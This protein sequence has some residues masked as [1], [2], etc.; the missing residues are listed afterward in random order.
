MPRT[1]S[2]PKKKSKS[3]SRRPLTAEM[4][5]ALINR[6]KYRSKKR[7]ARRTIYKAW[8]RYKTYK[9]AR[10]AMNRSLGSNISRRVGRYL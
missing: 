9:T 3:K 2:S 5:M 10:M 8:N 7:N 6:L 1:K 4:R